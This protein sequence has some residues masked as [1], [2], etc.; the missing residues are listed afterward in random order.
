MSLSIDGIDTV[1]YRHECV[2]EPKDVSRHYISRYCEGSCGVFY[3]SRGPSS[4]YTSVF[5]LGHSAHRF[6]HG[7]H[8][9]CWPQSFTKLVSFILYIDSVQRPIRSRRSFHAGDIGRAAKLHKGEGHGRGVM[10]PLGTYPWS[11]IFSTHFHEILSEI[12]ECIRNF[13]HQGSIFS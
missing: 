10:L 12:E 1:S 3:E 9:G 7:D 13:G 11:F 4:L 6:K 8:I 2:Y 5:R